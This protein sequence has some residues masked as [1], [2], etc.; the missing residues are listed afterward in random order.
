MQLINVTG[1]QAMDM[2]VNCFIHAPS[3]LKKRILLSLEKK[4]AIMTNSKRYYYNGFITPFEKTIRQFIKFLY[5]IGCNKILP[6]SLSWIPYSS[7][8]STCSNY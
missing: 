7:P 8:S 4:N 1:F 6:T 3:F 5:T 2:S